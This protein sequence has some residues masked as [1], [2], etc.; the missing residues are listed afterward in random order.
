MNILLSLI[1]GA[2]SVSPVFILAILMVSVIIH[3]VSHGYTAGFLGDPTAKYEGRLTLNPISHLDLF[4]SFIVP[5][6]TY[7]STGMV[8]GWAKPVPYNP[9]NLKGGKWGPAIVALAGP[10]ANFVVALIFAFVIKFNL[11]YGFL[12]P[13]ILVL[14]AYIVL[15]NLILTF[16]NL[17]PIPPF[18]G[19]KILFAL[20][21]YKYEWIRKTIETFWLLALI[22]FILF[23]W[24]SIVIFILDAFSF[25]FFGA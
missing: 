8:F 6:L 12:T 23:F 14:T 4:G 16:F 22:V 11:L 15:I 7:M 10:L 18:D 19:S 3:E 5:L 13:A 21:P 9:Y 17:I 24:Q 20:L 2:E 25:S 1:A